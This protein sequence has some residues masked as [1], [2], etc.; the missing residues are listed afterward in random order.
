MGN[1]SATSASPPPPPPTSAPALPQLEKTDLT[2][3]VT[4]D[5]TTEHLE[6]PGTIEDL[7]KRC[8]GI[9]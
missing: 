1:V 6:N 5:S 3:G 9:F 8:K 7:H 4:N 2:T